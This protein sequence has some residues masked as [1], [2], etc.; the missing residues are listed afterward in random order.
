ML[1]KLRNKKEHTI[2]YVDFLWLQNFESPQKIRKMWV[3]LRNCYE[4][5]HKTLEKTR[6]MKMKRS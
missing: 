3:S 4:S 6:E 2:N 1:K 5:L